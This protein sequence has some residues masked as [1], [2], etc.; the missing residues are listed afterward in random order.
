MQ[1]V[2]PVDAAPLASAATKSSRS[3]PPLAS[4]SRL[5]VPPACSTSPQSSPP[6]P[7]YRIGDSNI[8]KRERPGLS[9]SSATSLPPRYERPESLERPNPASASDHPSNGSL[10]PDTDGEEQEQDD[11][12]ANTHDR[13]SSLDKKR[14]VPPK[15]RGGAR[16]GIACVTCRKRKIRCSAE[17][18]KCAFCSRK[19]LACEY[20]GHPAETG[21]PLMTIAPGPAPIPLQGQDILPSKEIMLEALEPF[22]AHYY[23][24]FYFLHRP[25]LTEAI[26]RGIEPNADGLMCCVLAFAARFCVTLQALYPSSPSAASEHFCSLASQILS[27]PPPP[28]NDHDGTHHA[29]RNAS[30]GDGEIS[31]I[32]CQAFLMLGLYECTEG[33]E[34]KGWLKIGAAIRL[35]QVMKLGASKDMARAFPSISEADSMSVHAGFEDEEEGASSRARSDPL[36]AE[37]RR[38][39]FWSLFLLD[40]TVSDGKERPCSLKAPLSMMLRLP[41]PDQDFILGRPTA[42]ARFEADPKPWSLSVKATEHAAND[43]TSN[44]VVEVDLYGMTLRV[45]EIWQQVVTYVGSGGRNID[46]RPPW[47]PES[48]FAD[49][50]RKLSGF[51]AQLSP[52]L[53]ATRENLLAYTLSNQGRLFGMLHILYS[54]ARLVL[55][56]DYLPFLPPVDYLASSGPADGEPLYG[57]PNVVAP[58][59]WW[60]SSFEA[61]IKASQTIIQ[62]QTHLLTHHQTLTH[63]FAGFAA[64]TTGTIMLHLKYWP[65]NRSTEILSVREVHETIE[66]TTTI[67][68]ALKD[69]YPVGAHWCDGLAKL[70]LLYS[71][72]VRGV[73]AISD[74]TKVRAGVIK[75]LRTAKEEGTQPE[76]TAATPGGSGGSTGNKG[77]LSKGMTN[78][79]KRKRVKQDGGSSIGGTNPTMKSTNNQSTPT[80]TTSP[81][82]T[83]SCTSPDGANASASTTPLTTS[84]ELPHLSLTNPN[85]PSYFD[86]NNDLFSHL[87]LHSQFDLTPPANMHAGPYLLH[88]HHPNGLHPSTHEGHADDPNST[89]TT[90]HD[91]WSHPATFGGWGLGWNGFGLMSSFDTSPW[92]VDWGGIGASA[93]PPTTVPASLESPGSTRQQGAA[94]AAPPPPSGVGVG[95]GY[96]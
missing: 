10:E 46:R 6:S 22:F 44:K 43:S 37:T 58:E 60:S 85:D 31:L 77:S 66:A 25:T 62:V 48:T 57:S 87:D 32:R 35:A 12:D 55:H 67:L 65:Q 21:G 96:Y 59:G 71:N 18:P 61:A 24:T 14:S 89:T 34:N 75:M 47:M 63:P 26:R 69:V 20:H 13:N 30:T 94:Q 72:H 38:R 54:T 4:T 95:F 78:E 41:G 92:S 17:W 51:G 70:Q 68:A 81:T 28:R 11:A 27:H 39:T 3:T 40:R 9:S 74:P 80:S 76:T 23:D 2:P 64:L 88:P 90:S 19:K 1:F 49:L 56:R 8:K 5:V 50:Q 79:K 93:P 33:H 36:L 29:T 42:G 53:Q 73:L 82:T 83:T 45:A 84:K 91:F 15:P 16:A 52:Q 86:P 7:A